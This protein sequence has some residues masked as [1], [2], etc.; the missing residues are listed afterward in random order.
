MAPVGALLERARALNRE[1]R[2][3]ALAVLLE[4]VAPDVRLREPELGLLLA[5]VSRRLGRTQDALELATAVEAPLRRGG[6]DRLL[7]SRHNLVGMLLFERGEIAAAE[8]MWLALLEDAQSGSDAE[9]IARATQNLGVVYT[10]TDRAQE[11]M[12][13]HARAIAAYQRLGH[14]RGLAQAHQNLAIA[15]RDAG[16]GAQAEQHFHEAASHARADGSADELARVEQE[17][18][19]LILLSG[20]VAL[21]RTT[22]GNAMARFTRLGDPAG[23]A[24]VHR[25]LGLTALRAGDA[26]GAR[27]ALHRALGAGGNR[28]LAAEVHVALSALERALGNASAADTL[29]AEA[30][31]SFAALGA[32]AW[33]QRERVRVEQ[34]IRAA[35]EDAQRTDD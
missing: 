1:R 6:H 28:L 5:D 14:R 20:D 15:Y 25:V 31:A 32:H 22:A 30:E 23:Q 3:P 8:R 2:Y 19:L 16:F 34:I 21:A 26:D 12:T 29:D 24:E 11:A 13:C 7:R 9:W 18:A 27:A 4:S 17:R 10:L 33:G 35:T